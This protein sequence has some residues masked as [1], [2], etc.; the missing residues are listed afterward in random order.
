MVVARIVA[1]AGSLLAMI[2]VSGCGLLWSCTD[3]TAERGEA[4]VRV[5]IVDTDERPV[6]I[7]AE[8]TGW[9]R[10]PHPQVPEEG[11]EIHFDVRFEG[12][13]RGIGPAVDACA[14]D[15]DRVVLGCQTV[16]AHM[17]FG[18]D[19]TD[20]GDGYLAVDHPERVATVLLVPNDQS[21]HDRRTCEDDIKDGGGV[22]PPDAPEPGEQL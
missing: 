5:E 2:G 10:D 18:W 13:G 11:D 8:V 21:T 7:T 19:T 3:S 14:V 22:H 6:G 15:D 1:G 20:T 12:P 17:D 4:D 9:R 16:Y